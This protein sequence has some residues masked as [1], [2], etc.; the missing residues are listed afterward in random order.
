MAYSELIKNLDTLRMYIRSF[1]IYG[2]KTRDKFFAKSP[3]TYDDEKRRLENYLDGYMSFRSDE[4]GKVTFVSI[5]SRHTAHNPLYKIFKAKSFTAMDISLHFMLMDI[6]SDGTKKT[7]SA[8]LDEIIFVYLKG[9]SSEV[10][11]EESTLRKKLKEYEE[12]GLISSEKNGKAMLYWRN[13]MTELSGMEDALSFFSEAAPLGV[14]GSFLFD[15]LSSNPHLQIQTESEIFS[16][17]HHYITASIESDFVEQVFE[18]IREH[19][20]LTIE[21]K[22]RENG[23]IFSS[24]E[25]PLMIYQSVQGG[26]MYLMAFR[27]HGKYFLA[28]RFDYIVSMKTGGIYDGFLQRRSEFENLRKFIWGVALKQNKKHNDTSTTHVTFRIHFEDDEKFIYSRLVREKR[29]GKVTLLDNNNAQFDADIFDPQEI[30][31]WA[32]TFISRITFFDCTEKSIVRHF[33]DDIRK[34][35]ALYAEKS[36]DENSKKNS[37]GKN[38]AVQ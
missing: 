32:R 28:L 6:L 29:I 1:Y 15:N 27:P 7:L 3:R 36:S 2:F 13:P 26:R 25:V 37:E 19:R 18:A 23:R 16:F 8:I 17:K 5:D 12:L 38:D 4:N 10:V 21:Q 34:M 24:V 20:Y 30:I 14:V 33:F 31:P 9:F 22:R 35:N 11:P